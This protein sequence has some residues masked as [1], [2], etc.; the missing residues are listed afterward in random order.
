[1]L[2]CKLKK[3]LT[4]PR[5]LHQPFVEPDQ[6]TIVHQLSMINQTC[7]WAP[8]NFYP[9]GGSRRFFQVKP[10]IFVG[11]AKMG[12]FH[13][14][15]PKLRKQPSLLKNMIG[16]CQISKCRELPRPTFTPPLPTPMV[17]YIVQML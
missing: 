2:Q 12:K 14:F 3:L 13:F 1:M 9:G 4:E 11:G 15:H 7:T 17:V 16:T 10:R 8:E 6:S 5:Q